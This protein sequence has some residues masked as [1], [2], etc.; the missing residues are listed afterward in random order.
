MTNEIKGHFYG[1]NTGK[2]EGNY[3]PVKTVDLS[4][5]SRILPNFNPFGDFQ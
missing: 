3:Q 1:F 4:D 2:I 5:R